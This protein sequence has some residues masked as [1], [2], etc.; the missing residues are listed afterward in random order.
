MTLSAIMP[1]RHAL[2]ASAYPTQIN[3][4]DAFCAKRAQGTRYIAPRRYLG[5]LVEKCASLEK[6]EAHSCDGSDA[7]LFGERTAKVVVAFDIAIAE[8]NQGAGFKM[9]IDE[10]PP[11]ECDAL[12][13]DGGFQRIDVVPDFDG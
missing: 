3:G 6:R 2:L 13:L 7:S 11:A 1:I 12:S 9:P 8:R 10:V 5:V 4:V